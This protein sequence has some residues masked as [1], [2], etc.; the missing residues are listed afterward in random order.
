[1]RVFPVRSIKGP[2]YDSEV[3]LTLSFSK[4][5]RV[6]A[7]EYFQRLDPKGERISFW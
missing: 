6:A 5:S 1:M 4:R 3:S 2:R 7:S